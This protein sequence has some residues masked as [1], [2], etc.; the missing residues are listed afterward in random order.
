MGIFTIGRI[1]VGIFARKQT[2]KIKSIEIPHYKNT[3]E[4]PTVK[5]PVPDKVYINLSQ[6]MGQPCN[7]L[8]SVGD[9]VKVGQKIGDTDSF[10]S[11]P[12][13]SSVSG[14]VA[15]LDQIIMPNGIRSEVLVIEADKKQEI[16][17]DVKPPVITDKASFISAV[18][19]SGIVGLGGAGF[20]T[21]VKLDPKNLKDIDTLVINAAECEPFI[22]SDYRT[23][24]EKSEDIAYG[25][26]ETLKFLN[27]PSCIIGIEDNKPKAIELL[28]N[29]FK[30]CDNIKVKALKSS[31]PKGAE[32][33]LIFETAGKVVPENK[34]PADVGVIVMNVTTI[35]K[36]AEFLK[37][38]MPLTAK[39]IT[40]DGCVKEPKNAEVL[41]G[42]KIS[43]VFSFCG[44]FTKEV[45]KVM[46]GG[47]MMG[48]AIYDMDYPV[49]KN[50]NAIL[51]F[52][53]DMAPVDDITP[54]IRCG[55]CVR[56]CPMNLMPL[57]LE[58]AFELGD[59]GMLADY[60]VNLCM[61]C[62]CCSYVCP[63][64]R[65]LVQ[66]NR[67]SKARLRASAAKN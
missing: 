5:M 40:V 8:V 7:A 30:D 32:K 1:G 6:H 53:V 37:T 19:A 34:L 42:T 44:G 21:H 29:M 48:T 38:G 28:S 2:S 41:I 35:A 56:A 25:I 20:P 22:T 62:G 59:N 18:K 63:A 49:L 39:T 60:K 67:L 33:V 4:S 24:M 50:N 9:E 54:C 17:G 10:F 51:A 66:V 27:I 14:R 36:V 52:G 15:A 43:E 26:N 11:A 55:R 13:H 31:Y 65:D 3:S 64:R 47:P 58:T 57:K 16:S 45:R 23:I 12:V 46:M 61:E